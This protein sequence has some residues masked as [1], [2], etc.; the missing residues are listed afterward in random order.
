MGNQGRTGDPDRLRRADPTR[1]NRAPHRRA[2]P[3]RGSLGRHRQAGPITGS[4]DRRRRADPTRR[5]G[6]IRR[7]GPGPDSSMAPTR[8]IRERSKGR[9]RRA[10]PIRDLRWL[11]GIP[12]LRARGIRLRLDRDTRLSP[13]R[14]TRLS[15]TPGR[16]IRRRVRVIRCPV[17]PMPK[18]ATPSSRDRRIR[19][20]GI[21]VRVIRVP[22]TA[23]PTSPI[24]LRGI[25]IRLPKRTR[26]IRLP[27]R[28]RLIRSVRL[29]RLRV[30]PRRPIRSVPPT[31]CHRTRRRRRLSTPLLRM[32]RPMR[33]P[34]LR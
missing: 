33:L 18:R 6:R 23:G 27:R 14:D 32:V 5:T 1:D 19:D 15:P 8:H 25:H 34:R 21:R 29:I 3:T 17:S 30:I 12:C 28:V 7:M 31:R 4:L 13:G 26:D 20:R 22:V 11:R 10:P 24:P 9:C 16:P 2:D